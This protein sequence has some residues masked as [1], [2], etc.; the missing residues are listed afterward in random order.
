MD[1]VLDSPKRAAERRRGAP[2]WLWI[3]GGVVVLPALLPIV[4]LAARV[5]GASDSAWRALLSTT[6]LWLLVRSI[7]FATAVTVSASICGV[8]AAWL[9]TRTTLRRRR[10]W[11]TLVSLPLVVPSYV[12]ALSFL[13]LSGPRGLSAQLIG[14]AVP[15]VSGGFGAW[16]ALTLS[17]Y[18][19]VFLVVRFL[20]T[21]LDPSHEEA[22]RSLGAGPW[23]AFRTVVLPQLRPPIAAG[24]LLVGLYTLSDFGAVSLMR[25]DVLT[26]AIYT[27]YQGRIDRTP[28]AV[29]SL[30]LVILALVILAI[31]RRTRPRGIHSSRRP[32]RPATLIRL[33]TPQHRSGTIFLGSLVGLGVV[34]P[35]TVLVA[36]LVRGLGRDQEIGLEWGA[37]AGSISGAT[38]AA[39]LAMLAAIP[40]AVLVVR[41]QS[42]WS[43]FLQRSVYVIFSLPH[44]AVALAIVFFGAKYLGAFYQSLTVLVIAYATIFLA[45][46]SGAAE[47]ALGQVDPQLED[48]ARS[49]GSKPLTVLSRIT[50][51]LMW[52][53]L[54]AGGGLVFLTTMKELPATLLL[55]P[56]GFDTLAV[57]I[58]ST[59]SDLFYARAA[60]PALLLVLVSALPM[61]FLV[62]R[63]GS[64]RTTT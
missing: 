50:V 24:A 4:F 35:A 6:T 41:H 22:A 54:V 60:A 59:T 51:P 61:Y 5:A 14:L 28:A 23:R 30:V 12:L 37:L 20:M 47:A 56:T 32:A 58:W 2:A 44:I 55:R 36:W 53:G 52:R 40:V 11:A 49:L 57:R 62:I 3:A 63:D 16:L 9:V 25:F 29:L 42:P 34:V 13:S 1:P 15:S 64:D 45:Q 19:Y 43:R 38:L 10:L 46:A 31:E 17:T 21:R 27:Q 33:T 48:A 7:V 18:P 39:L 26:R 8:T